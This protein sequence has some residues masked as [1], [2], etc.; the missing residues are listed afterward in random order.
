MS[1]GFR[2]TVRCWS[3]GTGSTGGRHPRAGRTALPVRRWRHRRHQRLAQQRATQAGQRQLPVF[4]QQAI[5]RT[6]VLDLGDLKPFGPG[7]A[8]FVVQQ[9]QLAQGLGR[10]DGGVALKE[11]AAAIGR[12]G[13]RDQRLAVIA[14]PVAGSL[15]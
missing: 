7:A 5:E 10:V 14:R 8:F 13:T 9:R 12:D 2:R 11:F 6:G 4:E 3:A 15:E 1:S